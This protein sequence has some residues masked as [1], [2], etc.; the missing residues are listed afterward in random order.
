MMQSWQVRAEVL[1]TENRILW[2]VVMDLQNH[3]PPGVMQAS[4]RSVL[5]REEAVEATKRA[6]LEMVSHVNG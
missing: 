2:D 1:Q 6:R 3:L 5:A 4:L